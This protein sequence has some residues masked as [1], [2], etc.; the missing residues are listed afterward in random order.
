MRDQLRL[1]AA[2]KS[3]SITAASTIKINI[4][5]EHIAGPLLLP[6]S[7]FLVIDQ[8]M[9]P[10]VV[11]GPPFLKAIGFDLEKHLETKRFNLNNK[12]VDTNLA[13]TLNSQSSV[14]VSRSSY[15]G[16]QYGS[17]DG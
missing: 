1:E 12:V 4:A 17:A 11:L 15:T 3:T 6:G 5:L 9:T 13:E 2:A 7:E 14:N 10:Q 8:D 16:L